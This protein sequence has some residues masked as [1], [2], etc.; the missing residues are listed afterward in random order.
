M[1]GDVVTL[2]AAGQS[3]TVPVAIQPGQAKGS[4]SIAL[5]YGRSMIGKAGEGVG[6]NVWPMVDASGDCLVY[7]ASGA[8]VEKTGKTYA[9]LRHRRISTSMTGLPNVPL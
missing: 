8:T 3:V 9:L 2:K 4:A 5:G 7:C 1:H 6:V